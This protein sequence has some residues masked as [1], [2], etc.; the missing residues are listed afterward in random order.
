MRELL[1]AMEKAD[2]GRGIYVALNSVSDTATQFA[3]KNGVRVLFGEESA[4][5]AN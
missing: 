1:A 5:F 3:A 2:T 4:V